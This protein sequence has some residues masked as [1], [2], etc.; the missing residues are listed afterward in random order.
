MTE[1]NLAAVDQISHCPNLNE[2]AA[3][4]QRHRRTLNTQSLVFEFFSRRCRSYLLR[5]A[6][7]HTHFRK[8]SW[9]NEAVP[10]FHPP[11]ARIL[12]ID[13]HD[14]S[15]GFL[16]EKN[17]A[18]PKFISRTARTIGRN[19]DIAPGTKNITQLQKRRGTHA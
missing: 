2:S 3:L 8:R 1:C 9:N 10:T 4:N 11:A 15:A 19:Q 7:N 12:H 17:N 5:L 6:D 14:R 13:R 18:R 16:S